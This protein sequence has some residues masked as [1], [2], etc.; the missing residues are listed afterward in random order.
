MRDGNS[1]RST[2]LETP[3]LLPTVQSLTN[4]ERRNYS[5]QK[6]I[7]N[8]SGYGSPGLEH[9]VSASIGQDLKTVPKHGGV[10]V[11]FTMSGL[12]T[13]TN[14]G[15]NYLVPT[16]LSRN[17]VDALRAHAVCLRAGATFV[18]GLQSNFQLPTEANILAATWSSENPGSDISPSD[19]SLGVRT[20]HAHE[21][22][23]CTSISRQLLRQSSTDLNA[24]LAS[25]IAKAHAQLLDAAA[26]AGSGSAN[27]P[28]GILGTAI[29]S[30]T[31]GQNGGPLTSALVTSLESTVGAA[32][33]DVG[34]LGWVT[35][36]T[37][38]AKLRAIAEF[39]GGALPIWRD[40]QM[41]SYPAF[42]SNQCPGN[43][44]KGSSN[45]CSALIFG[46]WSALLI[47][48]F[49]GAVELVI[50]EITKARQGEIELSSYAS[51]DIG[52]TTVGSLAAIQDAI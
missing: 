36:S 7:C 6:L 13:T 3:G 51:Y 30:V 22:M 35:N 14:A 50:D 18:G 41:L 11:P 26:I 2:V 4:H 43:L 37:Q 29:G 48:E 42:S 17:I 1:Q 40:G 10:F 8:L 25:R 12:D 34:S 46:D 5:L 24:W 52:V 32:N 33:G 15:G 38:R 44:V 9:E 27:Q 21:M 16:L 23:A 49:G 28:L 45:N 47:A 20:L 19:P 31:V 39:T